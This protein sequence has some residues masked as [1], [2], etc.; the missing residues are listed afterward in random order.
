MTPQLRARCVGRDPSKLSLLFYTH[1]PEVVYTHLPPLG[2]SLALHLLHSTLQ[3]TDKVRQL[4]VRRCE[5]QRAGGAVWLPSGQ[6]DHIE[7]AAGFWLV[8]GRQQGA[9]HPTHVDDVGRAEATSL[10]SAAQ[11]VAT[12]RK[13]FCNSARACRLNCS[14]EHR[15]KL[16]RTDVCLAAM[17]E[18]RD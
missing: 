4:L 16:V 9:S 2:C 12:S 17:Q 13:H 15:H 14:R 11:C 8:F 10:D 3:L 1:T 5:L 6:G 7:R 18:Q